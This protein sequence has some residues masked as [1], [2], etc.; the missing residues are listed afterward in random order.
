M[1]RSSARSWIRCDP[2]EDGMHPE[3]KGRWVTEDEINSGHEAKWCEWP[4]EGEAEG[5]PTEGHRCRPWAAPTQVDVPTVRG[6]SDADQLQGCILYLPVGRGGKEVCSGQRGTWILR[7]Q[8]GGLWIGLWTTALGK[9]CSSTHEAG[10][11]YS[12]RSKAAVLHLDGKPA[13]HVLAV[14]G[15]GGQAGMGEDAV[16]STN[17]LDWLRTAVEL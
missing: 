1:G 6:S 2:N 5:G 14:A 4:H 15:T 10:N 8:G 17:Q 16:G 9:S 7:P 3:N 12:T 13:S 11:S